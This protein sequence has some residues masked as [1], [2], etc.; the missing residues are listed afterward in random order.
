MVTTREFLEKATLARETVDR[1]LAPTARNWATFDP[2]LGY[3]VRDN[4]VK[5]GVFGSHTIS[6]YRPLGHR[7]LVNYADGPCRINTYGNSFTQCQQV[8]NGESWQEYLAAH[9]GEPIRNYGVGGYGVFQAYRRMLREEKTDQA[10][11]YIILNVWSDDHY[12]SIYKWR[13]IDFLED[14]WRFHREATGRPEAAPFSNNPW[15]HLRL[16]TASRRFEEQPNPYPTPESLYL[17]CDPGHVYEAFKDDFETQAIMA[18][19]YVEDVNTGLISETSE[20]LGFSPDLSTPE[21]VAATAAE[22]LR[23]CAL[24]STMYVVDRA[25]DFVDR[26]AKKLLLVLSFSSRDVL[27]ACN[28]Q[29]RFDQEFV[30]YLEAEGV[31]YVDGLRAH[32]DEFQTF[33]STPE[34]YV[35]RYYISHYN[36]RGNHFYAFAIKD[37]V[38]AWLDP[39]PPTYRDEDRAALDVLAESRA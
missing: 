35:A 11:E 34:E 14:G 13:W 22:A 17:L 10:A 20:A 31:N 32:T 18:K 2:E 4:V 27:A 3:L 23:L 37:A 39:K 15:T 8:S 7:K 5:D 33:R 6:S 12:R 29:P 26:E 1:Y 30:D 19:Q 24:R 16:D 36:P 38:V 9:F 25:R 28:G 21:A